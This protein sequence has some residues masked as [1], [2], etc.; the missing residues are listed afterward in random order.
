MTID[1]ALYQ[2]YADLADLRKAK[3]SDVDAIK[4]EMAT[5][6]R[7]LLAAAADEGVASMTVAKA[8]GS[9][10][11]V[12]LRRD[13]RARNLKGPDETAAAIASIPD[14]AHLAMPRVNMNSLASVLRDLEDA[15]EPLPPELDGIV[16]PLEQFS[17]RVKKG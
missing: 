12:Y 11:I 2:R 9:K 4:E 5:I 8:D 15:G 3:E 13:V 1:P 10:A 7:D 6:E 16:E 14:L 17:M